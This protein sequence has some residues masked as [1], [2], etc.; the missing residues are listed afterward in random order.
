YHAIG[1]EGAPRVDFI[2]SH[3]K[4]QP[5]ILEINTIPGMTETSLLPMAAL[6][7]GIDFENLAERMLLNARLK[8]VNL[9]GG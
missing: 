3:K 1:C 6:H 9:R 7:A 2:L 5:Y 4:S 8:G